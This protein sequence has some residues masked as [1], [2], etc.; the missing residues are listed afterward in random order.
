MT[1]LPAA[2]ARATKLGNPS[3]LIKASSDRHSAI[4]IEAN[5]A[6]ATKRHVDSDGV[7]T[8][9]FVQSAAGK[10][11]PFQALARCYCWSSRLAIAV[12]VHIRTAAG[13]VSSECNR[14]PTA[15]HICR[16]KTGQRK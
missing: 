13:G 6:R 3:N 4:G 5:V 8:A 11:A 12:Y 2:E 9:V 10:R 1:K 15:A 7:R 16:R 14:N